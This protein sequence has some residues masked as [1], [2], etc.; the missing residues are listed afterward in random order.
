MS[1]L[2]EGRIRTIHDSTFNAACA[3]QDQPNPELFRGPVRFG[4]AAHARLMTMVLARGGTGQRLGPGWAFK[5]DTGAKLHKAKCGNQESF[6]WYHYS[7]LTG[8]PCVRVSRVCCCLMW[9][10]GK[11]VEARSHVC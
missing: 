5:T 10:I 3:T 9:A 2:L 1:L 4:A 11:V 7:T 8:K 6:H